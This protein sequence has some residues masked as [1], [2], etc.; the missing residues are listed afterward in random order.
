[1]DLS[2]GQQLRTSLTQEQTINSS[3]IQSLNILAAPLMELQGLI[4]KELEENPVLELAPPANEESLELTSEKILNEISLIETYSGNA[5]VIY[6]SP[7]QLAKRQHFFDSLTFEVSLYEELL[8]QLPLLDLSNDL[9]LLTEKM[10]LDI[11]ERGFLTTK[12]DVLAL[13]HQA[14]IS[15]TQAAI[16]VIKTLEPFGVG[17]FDLQERLLVQ[18]IQSGKRQSL[19]YAILDR[20]FEDLGANRLPQICAAMKISMAVLKEAIDDIKELRPTIVK[21]ST[22][23]AEY[24]SE[25]IEVA[26][27]GKEITFNVLQKRIPKVSINSKYKDMLKDTSLSKADRKFIKEKLNDAVELM[28]QLANRNSTIE[29]VMAE[30]IKQQRDYFFHGNEALVPQTMKQVAKA[31]DCHETTISRTV[32]N[33]YLRSSF[34]LVPLKIFFSAGSSLESSTVDTTGVA[35]RSKVKAIIDAEDKQKPLSDAKITKLLESEGI[36]IARRTVAKYREGLGIQ[37]TS[38]RRQYGDI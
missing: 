27:C 12:V 19:A 32:A 22:S 30:I 34:G 23:E 13:E 20:H 31:I 3:Q 25:D 8:K 36:K 11:D 9:F 38:L 26:V 37:A 2:I 10:I 21:L 16:D 7:E 6:Q 35:V 1:M 24:I 33:K 28:H 15:L 17:C 18:L 4:N 29:L 5:E 14:S